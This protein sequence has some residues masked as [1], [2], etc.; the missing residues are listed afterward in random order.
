MSVV[1]KANVSVTGNAVEIAVG[2]VTTKAN[3][4]AIV[5]TNRQ[6]L[7]T[8][9]VTIVAKATTLV[10]GNRLNIDDGTVLI[11][12]WDGVIPGASMT[13]EPVQTSLG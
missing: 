7:S 13:W 8:G 6:N 5:T 1:A 9:T 12:K 4:T 10:T 11:K 3:A 2:D